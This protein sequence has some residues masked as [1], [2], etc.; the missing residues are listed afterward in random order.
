MW[1][2]RVLKI[3]QICDTGC[4]CEI[5]TVWFRS[6]GLVTELKCVNRAVLEKQNIF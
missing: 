4:M 6:D 5:M 1:G 3:L 2:K